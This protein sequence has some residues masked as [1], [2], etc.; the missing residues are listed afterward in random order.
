MHAGKPTIA[1]IRGYCIGGGVSVALSCDM[2]ISAEGARFGV[3]A[4]KLGLGYD[5]RG[6][7]KLMDVV[8][9]SFAK[10]IFFTARQF[11]AQE[12]L[13]MGLVNRV[14]PDAQLEAYVREYAGAP[15][16]PPREACRKDRAARPWPPPAAAAPEAAAA[17]G[18]RVWIGRWLKRLW[19]RLR[20]EL[21]PPGID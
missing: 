15:A 2:R 20:G 19:R 4:A 3:P 18:R 6:V 8:G 14:L 13:A 7:R 10:E 17:Q 16:P 1:M 5:A 9:P 12:A 11:T 21:A